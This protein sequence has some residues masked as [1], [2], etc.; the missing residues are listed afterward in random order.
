MLDQRGFDS[1]EAY[2]ASKT[3]WKFSPNFA[4]KQIAAADCRG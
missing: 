1:F 2:L 3:E 4:Y